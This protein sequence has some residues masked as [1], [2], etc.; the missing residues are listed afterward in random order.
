[1]G[2]DNSG[3]PMRSD[4]TGAAKRKIILSSP[5]GFYPKEDGERRRKTIRG[6]VI[7]QEIVQINTIIVR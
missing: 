3:F 6:N 4:V 2:S 1:G 5:P 7:S